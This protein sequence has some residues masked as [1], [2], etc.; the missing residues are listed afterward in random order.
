MEEIKFSDPHSHAP[1]G[2]DGSGY[3]STNVLACY[4]VNELAIN[5]MLKAARSIP[6]DSNSSVFTLVDYGAADG[7]TSMPLVYACVKEL[8]KKYGD[9]LAIHVIYEDQPINDFKSLFM[10][11][12]GLIPGPPSFHVDFPNVFV[13]ASGTSFYSQCVP[14]NSVTIGFSGTA[15][16]WLRDKPCDITDATSYVASTVPEVKQKYREQAEK[17]W[18]LILMKRAAELMP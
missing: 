6:V 14:N 16:H 1:Y 8:R 18:E 13:T 2:K 11:L 4:D 10:L 5:L 17:D 3:Y 9:E 15:F 7:G 12:Q